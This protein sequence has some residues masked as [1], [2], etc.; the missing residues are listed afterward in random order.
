MY[1][2]ERYRKNAFN[3]KKEIRSQGKSPFEEKHN[4]QNKENK[5]GIMPVN[6]LLINMGLPMIISM[7]VQALYNVVDSAFV[8]RIVDDSSEVTGAAGTAAL[9]AVGMA[10]PFQM[11]MIAFATGTT[12]GMNAMLSKALGAKDKDG[13]RKAATNGVFSMAIC[14][15]LFLIMGLFFSEILIKSQDGTGLALDYGTSYLRIVSV[16]SFGLFAQ[17]SV[18]RLMQSTG[19]SFYSMVIQLSGAIINIILDPI[20][21]FGLCGLPEMKV[22][23]AALATVIGQIVA[24]IIGIILNAKK[25][26]EVRLK[27]KGFRPD[28]KVIGRIYSVGLPSIVMQAIGSV[29]TFC[30]NRILAGLN[31]DSVAV[32]TIYFK[33]QSLFFMP[34]FGLNNAMIPIVAFNFGAKK[35]KRVIQTYRLS[36]VY[37]FAF[38][39]L[40]FLCFEIIP[41]TLLKL[42]DTGAASLIELGV[43]ALRVIGIHYLAA[44]YCIVTGSVFQSL[45]NGLYCLIVSVARQLVVLVPVAYVLA[46]LGGLDL[47]WWS[48]PIAEVMSVIVTVFFFIKINNSIIKR[49]PDNK[50]EENCIPETE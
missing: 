37:A 23:G 47:V 41:E 33:L 43:P 21:I 26:P 34:I 46:E 40:G 14:Y 24:A 19:K 9:V 6:K 45:G 49:I 10:F 2:V 11:L 31:P 1:D 22:A 32:F 35:R 39:V 13:V 4:M 44:W 17:I 5:M 29:M 7:L 20:L 28:F 38:A 42:F 12:V 50:P 48:F 30:M 18:E 27:F 15:I 25:N 3:K 16:F 36:L 8:A